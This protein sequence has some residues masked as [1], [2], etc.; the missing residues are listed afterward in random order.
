MD[1]PEQAS[2][3]N[4][5]SE[6]AEVPPPAPEELLN[7]DPAGE[8]GALLVG[9]IVA[10][11]AVL[12]TDG[13]KS[14][15]IFTRSGHQHHAPDN[16]HN[17]ARLSAIVTI[18]SLPAPDADDADLAEFLKSPPPNGVKAAALVKDDNDKYWYVVS[19]DG[20]AQAFEASEANTE[21]LALNDIVPTAKAGPSKGSRPGR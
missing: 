3:Q 9:D 17:R 19:I 21:L 7:L 15:I 18:Q 2:T 13:T 1:Q 20:K 8:T 6:E 10:A 12:L 14:F 5:N 16:S 11:M 4:P